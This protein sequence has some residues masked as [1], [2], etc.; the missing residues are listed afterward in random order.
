MERIPI[1][2][3]AGSDHV[4]GHLPE[5]SS[6]L[7][8]LSTAYKGAEV[9]VEN[10]PLIAL[11]I[12]QI[13][14]SS[15]FGPITVAGPA[16]IYQPLE[17]NARI[18]DTDGG[19]ATNLKAA[20]EDHLER[21]RD[22]PIALLAYDVLLKSGDLDDL[23]S[24]YLQDEPCAVWVPFVRKPDDSK[25]LGAFGWKPAYSLLSDRGEAPVEILPGHLGIFQPE[26]M[27]LSILY[28]LLSL[29]YRT[30]NY[31]VATR[32]KVMIR[33]V[34]GKLLLDDLRSLCSLRVPRL[35]GSVLS[36]GLDIATRLKRGDLAIPELENA[37]G[38]IFLNPDSELKRSG[39]GVRHPIVDILRLAEDVDTQ[40][41][42]ANLEI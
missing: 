28:E 24:R 19:I 36:N 20:F 35:T 37:I 16:S 11:L 27:R 14:K 23:R 39:R 30:R 18:V 26:S 31:P 42:A 4:L 8:S 13:E 7:H 41:E 21:F 3:M 2:I 10:T 38:G 6:T 15:G 33:S 29:A 17:L 32:K 40:E 25:D 5:S 22:A 9:K 12:E 34:I 1:T